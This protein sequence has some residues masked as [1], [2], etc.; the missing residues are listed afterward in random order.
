MEKE[1]GVTFWGKRKKVY[2]IKVWSIYLP[3]NFRIAIENK[4]LQ[5]KYMKQSASV[6]KHSTSAKP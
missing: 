1:K 6:I 3:A 4:E 2:C 5:N